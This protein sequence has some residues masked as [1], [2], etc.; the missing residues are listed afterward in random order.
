MIT[1][2]PSRHANLNSWRKST[3]S[4]SGGACV[5]V[6][7]FNTEIRPAHPCRVSRGTAAFSS[8]V[9][10]SR[11]PGQAALY[12]ASAEWSAFLTSVKSGIL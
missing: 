10:D 3:Y 7:H 8:G 4:A 2:P 12:F 5:E 6:G 9:R 1:N 11:T